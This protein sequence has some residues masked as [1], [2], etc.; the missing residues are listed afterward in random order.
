MGTPSFPPASRPARAGKIFLAAR[1]PVAPNS[2]MTSVSTTAAWR[3]SGTGSSSSA[4]ADQMGGKVRRSVTAGLPGGHH[5]SGVG[6]LGDGVE[7]GVVVGQAGEQHLVGTGGHGHAAVE[8][9]VE[10]PGVGGLVG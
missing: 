2:T 6:R 4:S 1:S 9:G 8:Q 7:H 10:E 3:S 5:R